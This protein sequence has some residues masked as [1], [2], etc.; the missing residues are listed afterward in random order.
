[1][2]NLVTNKCE[3]ETERA[4][5]KVMQSIMSGNSVIYTKTDLTMI[6]NKRHIRLEAIKRLVQADLLRYEDYFWVEPSRARKQIK[7]DSKR[8]LRPG[9][10]KYES[11]DEIVF[12]Y[13]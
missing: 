8:I 6:C 4:V 10:L 12:I 7:K 1:L 13:Y 3:E 11:F 2:I 5:K 9:W